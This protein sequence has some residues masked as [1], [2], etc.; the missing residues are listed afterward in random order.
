[1]QLVENRVILFYIY[2]FSFV[3][4]IVGVAILHKSNEPNMARG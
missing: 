1:V 3:K 2:F 4:Y